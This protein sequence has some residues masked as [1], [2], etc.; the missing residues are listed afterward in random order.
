MASNEFPEVMAPFRILDF[1][2]S[3]NTADAYMAYDSNKAHAE[4]RLLVLKRIKPMNNEREYERIVADART[5]A[6]FK[7]PDVIVTHGVYE[8][9]GEH[10]IASPFLRG[11]SVMTL[12]S[13]EGSGMP[14]GLSL[15]AAVVL[16]EAAATATHA[17]HTS[18]GDAPP[19]SPAV[20]HRY[21][22]GYVRTS[23]PSRAIGARLPCA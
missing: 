19:G 20:V 13:S 11:E 21:A 8:H 6:S 17:I 22:S 9:N 15:H 4:E 3:G 23:R 2:G 7:H 10:W 12:A 16:V 1:L 18:G 5:A 14:L